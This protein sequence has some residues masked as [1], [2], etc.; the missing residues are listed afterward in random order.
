MT[1]PGSSETPDWSEP[2]A[3]E[4]LREVAEDLQQAVSSLVRQVRQAS[5]PQGVTLSQVALLKRLDREGPHTVAELARAEKVRHQSMLAT[6]NSA[7]AAGLVERSPHPTDGRQVL[8]SL[9]SDG[10]T[11]LT[12]RRQAGHD[13]LTSLLAE[14]LTPDELQTVART[15]ALLKRL[16]EE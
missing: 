15:A 16:A 9:S 8:I 12:E 6:V 5:A 4:L 1:P 11:F 7:E 3:P 14:R 2:V 10:H 13:R